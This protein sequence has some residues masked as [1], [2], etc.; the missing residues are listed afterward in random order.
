MVFHKICKSCLL[1]AKVTEKSKETVAYVEMDW[2]WMQHMR[3]LPFEV[4]GVQVSGM[5]QE[6]AAIVIPGTEGQKGLA[7]SGFPS[8]G[9]PPDASV[10]LY[11]YSWDSKPSQAANVSACRMEQAAIIV[12]LKEGNEIAEVR[13]S[14]TFGTDVKQRKGDGTCAPLI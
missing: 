2:L 11:G 1:N 8:E 7:L 10:N 12:Q 3:I 5:K 13:I 14:S 6:W 4:I 9:L